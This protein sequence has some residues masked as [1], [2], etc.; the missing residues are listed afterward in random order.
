[1]VDQSMFGNLKLTKVSEET[2][3]TTTTEQVV[4][5]TAPKGG[6]SKDTLMNFVPLILVFAI[7]YF[8]VIR[9]QLKK[10]K[11][12]DALIK[13]VKKGDRVIIAG[14]MFGKIVKETDK[15]TFIV[16]LA[17]DVHV[18]ILKSSVVS[19]AVKMDNAPKK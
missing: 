10:Q 1:M 4:E 16:E 13:A 17:K 5:S 19:L 3:V 2:T 14:G 9:P 15:D 6:F 18:E 8:F 12:Q 7:F 11:E